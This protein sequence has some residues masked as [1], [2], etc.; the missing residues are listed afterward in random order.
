[1]ARLNCL[2]QYQHR[3]YRD[4]SYRRDDLHPSGARD[5][6]HR[7]S[8]D[9]QPCDELWPRDERD[10]SYRGGNGSG[11]QVGRDQVGVTE[12]GGDQDGG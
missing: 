2:G 1:V 4:R 10:G 8:D 11:D 5:G 7:P 12:M 3:L 6:N 9:R